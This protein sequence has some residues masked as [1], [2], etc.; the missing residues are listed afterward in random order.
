MTGAAAVD[1]YLREVAAG[2]P[3][4]PGARRDILAELRAGLLDAVDAHRSAGLPPAAAAQAAIG[5]FG[6]P[7]QVAALF[8]PELA[9]RQARRL[10]VTL[11]ATGPLIGLLWTAAALASHI[12]IRHAPPWHWAGAPPL[13]PGAFPVLAGAFLIAVCSA[14]ATV[15]AT[16]RLTRRIPPRPRAAAAT[17]ATAGFAAAAADL[18]ILALLGSKLASAPATLAPLPVTAAAAASLARLA[19]ARRAAHQCLAVRAALA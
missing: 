13:S 18:A 15:A 1:A 16:G 17:A 3:G 4:P 8:R 9:V 5:E 7:C 14:L 6:D 11:V 2:L 12:A 10:A 19:L